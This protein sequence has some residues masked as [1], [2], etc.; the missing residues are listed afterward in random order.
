[1]PQM[2]RFSAK[3]GQLILMTSQKGVAVIVGSLSNASSKVYMRRICALQVI[4]LSAAV[5]FV[6]PVLITAKAPT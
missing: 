1:M 5:D 3:E 4:L 6:P 2:R